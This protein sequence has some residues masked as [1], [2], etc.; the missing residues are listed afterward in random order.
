MHI[1]DTDTFFPGAAASGN[2]NIVDAVIAKIPHLNTFPWPL[3]GNIVSRAAAAGLDGLLVAMIQS[4]HDMNKTVD[5]RDATPIMTAIWHD[6][7]ST[8]EL[9]LLKSELELDLAIADRTGELPLNTAARKGNPGVLEILLQGGAKL[10]IN[11]KQDDENRAVKAAAL[12]GNHKAIEMLLGAG[13][14]LQN[15]STDQGVR[16]YWKPSLILAAKNGFRECARVLLEH[17]ADPNVECWTGTVLYHAVSRGHV[18]VVRLLFENEKY[19]LDV[20]SLGK[21][22]RDGGEMLLLRAVS[23]GN[24]DLVSLLI[25]HGAMTVDSVYPLSSQFTKTPLSRA[26]AEGHLAVVKLLLEEHKADVNY[27]GDEQSDMP[28]LAAVY[29]NE[30]EVLDY[31]LQTHSDHIDA[32]WAA[33][34]GISP[35]HLAVRYPRLTATLLAMKR[36]P[37]VDSP[38]DF[39]TALFIA[40]AAGNAS[41]VEVLLRNDPKPDIDLVFED[42]KGAKPSQVGYTAL[43]YACKML[44]TE[45]VR[46]LLRAGAS[47]SLTNRDGHDAVGIILLNTSTTAYKTESSDFNDAQECLRLLLVSEAYY[48]R[49]SQVR[50]TFRP[51][52]VDKDQEQ[53]QEGRERKKLHLQRCRTRLHC[54]R[55][56]TPVSLVQILVEEARAPLDVQDDEDG[57]TPLSLAVKLGNEPVAKYLIDRGANVNVFSPA[58]GSI[59]HIA[60]ANGDIGMARLLV[61]SGA[62]REAVDRDFG[63]SLLYTALSRLNFADM[64]KMVR[65]LVD[66]AKVSVNKMGGPLRY[67]IIRAAYIAMLPGYPP[68]VST[69]MIK[70]LVRRGAARDVADTEGRRAVHLA[71]ASYWDDELRALVGAGAAIEVRDRLG[72]TPL[73]FAAASRYPDCLLYLLNLHKPRA[74]EAVRPDVGAVDDDGWTPLMWAARSGDLESI[75]ML[76][77]SQAPDVIWT[78]ST[79]QHHAGEWSALKLLRFADRD[80]SLL[81]AEDTSSKA[82][83]GWDDPFHESR[84]GNRTN[85]RCES[86]FSV[87]DFLN[88]LNPPPPLSFLLL[89]LFLCEKRK[90]AA[91]NL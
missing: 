59:L 11:G 69:S 75:A 35:L 46:L 57:H 39:G 88:F 85:Y 79:A 78:K 43:Q 87:S 15:D 86:C 6:R 45:C 54:I 13:A 17:G 32:S 90:I 66:E 48:L 25:R 4:G 24:A 63:E 12:H 9:L 23:T 19:K 50:T 22:P 51:G 34:D 64:P 91:Y 5:Y 10:D 68:Q 82:H 80:G 36:A 74:N 61:A 42:R 18:D 44:H 84:V 52:D 89:P 67:P 16:S 28:L 56:K 81:L 70:F 14:E 58:F 77:R 33:G 60:V 73:H 1:Y 7:I 72:R 49:G 26:C 27:T 2:A 38:S 8:V 47:S 83:P 30:L 21:V 3:E 76:M 55:K 41:T 62:D 71:A 40:A 37:E 65:Y 31:L 53:E 20:D 29:E